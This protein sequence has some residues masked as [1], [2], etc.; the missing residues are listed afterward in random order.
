MLWLLDISM[1]LTKAL[2]MHY[3]CFVWRE[4]ILCF[5]LPISSSPYVSLSLLLSFPSTLLSFFSCL[6]LFIFSS[7]SL[8]FPL[9]LPLSFS[10]P[11]CLSILFS[12]SSFYPSHFL[13]ASLSFSPSSLSLSPLSPF[14]PS[15]PSPSSPLFLSTFLEFSAFVLLSRKSH[16][17]SWN[18]RR[19]GMRLW[20]EEGRGMRGWKK[21]GRGD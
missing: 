19:E 4:E 1:Y 3:H 7:P 20:G 8:P 21:V 17:G 10:L 9:S 16:W 5:S 15:L 6:P 2:G 14:F 18:G 13:P 12:L 11:D